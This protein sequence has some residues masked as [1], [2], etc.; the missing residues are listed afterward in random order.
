MNQVA[1]QK[2]AQQDTEEESHKKHDMYNQ[3]GAVN[4]SVRNQTIKIPSCFL[5]FIFYH[6][7][8][9]P[10]DIQC[11]VGLLPIEE[12]SVGIRAGQAALDDRGIIG[13][14]VGGLSVLVGKIAAVVQKPFRINAYD[15]ITKCIQAGIGNAAYLPDKKK[16]MG[17][18]VF[19]Y[20]DRTAVIIGGNIRQILEHVIRKPLRNRDIGFC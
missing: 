15:K 5:N 14:N 9:M 11:H 7:I 8:F 4:L 2:N 6:E 12:E 20:P 13:K 18:T 17:L 1:G 10:A 3:Y 19:G 16:S